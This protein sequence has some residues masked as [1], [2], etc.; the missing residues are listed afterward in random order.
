MDDLTQAYLD[1]RLANT[2]VSLSDV[3]GSV[4]PDLKKAY[5]QLCNKIADHLKSVM[6][7]E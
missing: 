2:I 7:T 5:L 6:P 4:S 3:V 1:M